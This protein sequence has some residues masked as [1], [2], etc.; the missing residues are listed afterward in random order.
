L[1]ANRRPELHRKL[2]LTSIVPLALMIPLGFAT[3]TALIRRGFDLS[4]INT[5]ILSLTA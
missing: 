4:G 2:G 5:S 3:T 1:I